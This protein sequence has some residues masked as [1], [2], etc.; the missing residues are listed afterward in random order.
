MT[1]A[2]KL[3]PNRDNLLD[4]ARQLYA[5]T[6]SGLRRTMQTYRP[7]ICPFEA[8]ISHVSNG[9]RVLD[10]GCGSGLFLGLLAMHRDID[11]GAGFDLSQDAI[12]LADEMRKAHPS[13]DS[14]SFTALSV[15]SPWPEGTF[16]TISIVDLLHHL[17]KATQES[18]IRMAVTRLEPGGRLII[19]DMTQKPLWRAFFNWLHDLVVSREF[20]HAPRESNIMSWTQDLGLRLTYNETYNIVW[21]GHKLWIF[22]KPA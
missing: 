11:K 15:D 19:K 4:D 16:D 12:S 13:G 9:A 21:Y 10:V 14:L 3:T 1:A 5:T 6:P 18:T 8:L 20:V 22:E 7:L 17:D 2:V